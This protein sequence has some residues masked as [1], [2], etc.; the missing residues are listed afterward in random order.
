MCRECTL[1]GSRNGDHHH[2][3]VNDYYRELGGRVREARGDRSQA[4]LGKRSDLSR[5][6]IA[7]IELGRQ[8]VAVDVWLRIARALD[9]DPLDLLPT[10]PPGGDV[11]EGLKP[12]ERSA[13]ERLRVRAGLPIDPADDAAG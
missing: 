11:L 2:L 4:E 10:T 8:R 7:N 9:V 6:T 5:M 13:V 3:D 12:S 1:T